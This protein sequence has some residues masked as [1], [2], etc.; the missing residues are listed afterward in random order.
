MQ[1]TMH[2]VAKCSTLPLLQYST[3]FFVTH[4]HLHLHF[5][6]YFFLLF[7]LISIRMS[8]WQKPTNQF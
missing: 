1:L 5:F 3:H 8:M 7:T 6:F 4:L 2:E